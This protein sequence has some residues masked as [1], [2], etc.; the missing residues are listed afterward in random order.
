MFTSSPLYLQEGYF[1][2][3]EF[4]ASGGTVEGDSCFRCSYK[5]AGNDEVN[6]LSIWLFTR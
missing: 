5:N 3:D 6:K 2:E 4:V 1:S